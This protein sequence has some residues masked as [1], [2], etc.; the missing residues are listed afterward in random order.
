MTSP[1]PLASKS[2]PVKSSARVRGRQP[3]TGYF[4]PV[5]GSGLKLPTLRNVR[6]E[7]NRKGGFEAWHV[8][9]RTKHRKDAV[10]LGVIGKRR[11]AE[12]VKLSSDEMTATIV[13]W[14]ET[15]L[16]EKGIQL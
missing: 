6:W 7:Q 8:P 2:E 1:A 11:Q 10:Y 14:I 15:K 5:S 13:D 9:P 4:R 16:A 3:A 12:L